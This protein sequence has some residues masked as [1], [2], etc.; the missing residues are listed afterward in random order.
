M[1][2]VHEPRA[3][4]WRSLVTDSALVSEFGKPQNGLAMPLW[5]MVRR[6]KVRGQSRP[7]F[8]SPGKGARSMGSIL[9]FSGSLFNSHVVVELGWDRI[10]WDRPRELG[11]NIGGSQC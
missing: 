8:L 6:P 5:S 9:I 11:W 10:G 2:G 3:Y 4:L 7:V 1:Q